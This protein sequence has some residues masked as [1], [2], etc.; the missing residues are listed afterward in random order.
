MLTLILI[1]INCQ[2]P[3]AIELENTATYEKFDKEILRTSQFV[4]KL[5]ELQSVLQKESD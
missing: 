3:E 1:Y 2:T 5:K 4:A